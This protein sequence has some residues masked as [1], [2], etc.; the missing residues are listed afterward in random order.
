MYK[1]VRPTKD[2]TIYGYATL[3]NAGI[4]EVNELNTRCGID[5][6]FSSTGE[7]APSR[8]L[9]DFPDVG[10]TF[11][12]ISEDGPNAFVNRGVTS[13]DRSGTTTTVSSDFGTGPPNAFVLSGIERAPERQPTPQ[14]DEGPEVESF[15]SAAWLRMWFANGMGMPKEYEIQA[16]SVE[17]DWREG[18][19]RLENRPITD[20]P[21]NWIQR[22][23]LE[24]WNQQ[25]GDFSEFPVARQKFDG[26]DPDVEMRLN[27]L[28]SEG[29]D[30]GIILQRKNENIRN[31]EGELERISELKFFSLQTRTIYVPHL[32]VGEDTYTFEPGEAGPLEE[33][34][35]TAYIANLRNEYSPGETYRFRVTAER[36][37]EQR[38][39]LGIRPTARKEAVESRK[40]LPPRSLTY[41]VKDTRTGLE[42][43]PFSRK[44]TA[45]SFEEGTGHYFDLD[46]TSLFPKRKYEFVLRYEDPE[47]G[48][49]KLFETGQTF[50]IE[51]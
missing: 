11:T 45:V 21:V 31:S 4:D 13:V 47:T 17:A 1:L 33:E 5:R 19:G 7:L 28:L 41:Q 34:N 39:F 6:A 36:E 43:F 38:E 40:W 14:P 32:L 46:L 2:A 8:I 49:T 37:F 20:E 50:R 35:F 51:E 23:E 44:Y 30:N 18:R 48:N 3:V 24:D 27:T 42:F 9:M 29:I 10:Q 12:G 16:R 25:G 22:T 15:E 26:D